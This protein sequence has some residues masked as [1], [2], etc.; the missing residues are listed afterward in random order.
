MSP[1]KL[2]ARPVKEAQKENSRST[3]PPQSISVDRKER[4]G[5]NQKTAASKQL[6]L[7]HCELG[8]ATFSSG[9]R[10]LA[11]GAASPSSVAAVSPAPAVPPRLARTTVRSPAEEGHVR[12]NCGSPGRQAGENTPH[13]LGLNPDRVV[14]PP[15]LL[16]LS[17]NNAEGDDSELIQRLGRP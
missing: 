3:L 9:L 15:E 7:R 1:Y 13:V 14:F 10:R 4:K 8:L 11:G 16:D 17:A 6:S 12:R 5:R 2:W